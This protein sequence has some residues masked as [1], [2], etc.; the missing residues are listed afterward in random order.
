[1]SGRVQIPVR[2]LGAQSL[3]NIAQPVRAYSLGSEAIAALPAIVFP[4]SRP[5]WSRSKIARQ[6]VAGLLVV[7]A[8]A[9]GGATWYFHRT[10]TAPIASAVF[11]DRPQL[12]PERLSIVVLP[13][14]NL[15]GD[16]SQDYLADVITEELTTNLS[17]IAG[18]F[19]I[20]RSTAFTYKGKAVD[21]KQIGKDL[22]VRY[23][24]EGSAQH[25]GNRVRINAQLVSAETGAHLW[26]DQFDTDRADLLQMQDEIVTRLARTLEVQLWKVDAARVARTRPANPSAQDLALQCLAD[27]YVADRAVSIA[28][29]S[30][31][32]CERALQIDPRNALALSIMTMKFLLPV[33][34]LQST[35]PQEAIRQADEFVT[36]A[37]AVDPNLYVAHDYKAWVLISQ[38][39]PEEAIIEAER[40]L[41]LNPSYV[42][43]YLALN[44]AND[45][46]G[47]PE[48]ALEYV[49]K[50]IR[51]SP[52]DPALHVFYWNKGW[53]YFLAQQ[54]VQAIGWLRRVMA[55][56][57][58]WPLPNMVLAAALALDGNEVEAREALKHY[59]SLNGVKTR[60]ISAVTSQVASFSDTPFWSTYI[61]RLSEGL[62]RA[63]MPEE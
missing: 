6:A 58:E 50:A 53:A 40:S 5:F 30:Y 38:K 55:M 44:I 21:A 46:L 10:A 63:G 1:M 16:S 8:I 13:F 18:S 20:A 25:S 7:I 9:G 32:L 35:D 31:G 11:A 52:R 39:R 14:T 36:Q 4:T 49:D 43:A 42:D 34:E 45:V 59:L 19:V 23:A 2:D 60:S 57:P 37:L 12:I 54:D 26:A 17:R 15:S 56:W 22:G 33:L 48:R 41:T 47:R 29:A 27:R 51:L 3:K 28:R 61:K 62:R 24:L